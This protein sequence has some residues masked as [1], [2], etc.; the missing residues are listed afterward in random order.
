MP[1]ETSDNR[2]ILRTP[3]QIAR[4]ACQVANQADTDCMALAAKLEECRSELSFARIDIAGL[5]AQNL[6]LLRII[7]SASEALR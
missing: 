4:D 6:K 5:Q 1:A 2:A 3:G 7:S